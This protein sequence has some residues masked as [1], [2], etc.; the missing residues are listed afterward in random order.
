[1]CGF[2]TGV[3]YSAGMSS[4]SAPAA[5][6][7][8]TASDLVRHFGVWQDRAA[9]APVYI[10]HR[11]RPRL[12]LVSVETM[13][14]LCANPANGARRKPLPAEAITA[15]QLL[16]NIRDIVLLA[17]RE[18]TILASSRSARAH[19]GDISTPGTPVD[20]ITPPPSRALLGR[21]MQRVGSSGVGECLTVASAAR[22]GRMLALRIE[23][24]GDGTG[25]FAE[26][27]TP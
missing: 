17:D 22:I 8:V 19:F 27:V 24:I 15:T 2:A 23:P 25:I 16:D 13:N 4:P 14:A 26:D 11:G 21:A 5:E 3:A 9:R 18:A 12:V 1:V 10:L 6:Q 20:T 7:M